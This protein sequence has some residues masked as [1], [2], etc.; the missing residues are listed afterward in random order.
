MDVESLNGN[1]HSTRTVQC[2]LTLASCRAL[3]TYPMFQRVGRWSGLQL[4]SEELTELQVI[5]DSPEV[6]YAP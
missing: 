3:N 1:F 6:S 5:T 4:W 2:S